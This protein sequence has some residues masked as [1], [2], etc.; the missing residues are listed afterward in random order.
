M[1]TATRPITMQDLLKAVKNNNA[2]LLRTYLEGMEESKRVDILSK[3]QSSTGFT[4]LCLAVSMGHLDICRIL[5]SFGA[6]KNIKGTYLNGEY[7]PL[8]IAVCTG[9]S[10]IFELLIEEGNLMYDENLTLLE[11]AVGCNHIGIAQKLIERGADPNRSHP[12]A[13]P[14]HRKQVQ[15]DMVKNWVMPLTPQI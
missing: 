15:I 6:N 5:L 4:P 13:N 10:D 11:V 7:S 9:H 8:Q 1:S 3:K 2:D 14:D 12:W